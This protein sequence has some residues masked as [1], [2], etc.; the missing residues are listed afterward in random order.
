MRSGSTLRPTSR[1][2]FAATL[3]LTSGCGE[4]SRNVSV[5]EVEPAE[6]G[7]LLLVV[8]SCNQEPEIETWEIDEETKEVVV[9]VVSSLSD[10]GTECQDLIEQAF[11]QGPGWVLIDETS[12]GRF[13]IPKR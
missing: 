7:T 1:L 8:D 4:N 11:S 3:V 2:A 10:D 13:Q 9:S 6:A 5:V 12:G